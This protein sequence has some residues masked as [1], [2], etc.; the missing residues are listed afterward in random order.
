MQSLK[1]VSAD[2]LARPD[3]AANDSAESDSAE[4]DLQDRQKTPLLEGEANLQATRLVELLKRP[5]ERPG[6]TLGSGINLWLNLPE[7][8]L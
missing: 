1:G 8:C 3:S 2:R 5:F 6:K 4:S 7:I